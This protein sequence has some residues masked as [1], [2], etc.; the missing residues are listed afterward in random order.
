MFFGFTNLITA[1][2]TV[3]FV[4]NIFGIAR[5]GTL[6]GAIVMVHQIA[7]GF[8]AFLGAWIFDNR[9]G[10]DD[11]FKLMLILSLAAVLLTYM[12]REKALTGTFTSSPPGQ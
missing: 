9:G 7:G 2:L 5:L 12:V 1:P 6:T 4:G 10:Y 3:V 8:G 11:A